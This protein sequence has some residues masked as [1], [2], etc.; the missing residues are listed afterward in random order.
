MIEIWEMVEEIVDWV[1]VKYFNDYVGIIY[2]CS[3]EVFYGYIFCGFEG[4]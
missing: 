4:C 3:V 2:I 1:V